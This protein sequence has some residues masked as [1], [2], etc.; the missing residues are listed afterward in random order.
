MKIEFRKAKTADAEVLIDIYNA[1]FYCDYVRYGECPAYGRTVEMMKQSII[2]YP[3][4]LIVCDSSPVGC[5][6]CKETEKGT[7]EIGCLCVIPEFQ[8]KGI[9]TSAMEFAKSYYQDWNRF[10]LVTPVDKSENV[11]FYTE[12]CG[13]DIQ[14]VEMDG[15]VKVFRFILER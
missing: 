7:Y 4:F 5:V 3:K 6:S 1:A 8:G 2:N 13:F 10:T 12:K 15:N 9:G 11:R 14:S